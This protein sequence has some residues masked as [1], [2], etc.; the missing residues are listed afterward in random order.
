VTGQDVIPLFR[1]SVSDLEKRY[2]CEALD[3]GWWGQGPRTEEFEGRFAEYA[4]AKHAVAVSSCTAALHLALEALGVRGGQVICPALTFVSTGL[5]ALHAGAQVIFADVDDETLCLDWDDVRAKAGDQTRAVVPVH[6]GGTVTSP[7]FPWLDPVIEDCAH[8]AGSTRAG[9]QNG[10]A[11]CWSFQAV[12][13]LACGDGGMITTDDADIAGTARKLRWCGIERSTWERESRAG[14]NWDYDVP[15]AGWKYQM[16]DIAAAVGLAQLERIEDL[17]KA[18]RGLVLRYMAEL[19]GRVWLRTPR[20]REGSAWH[21]F[22][23]RVPAEM[24]D[25]LISHLLARGISAGVHYKPLNRYPV[26]GERQPLPVT[27]AAWRE[28]VTLPLFPDMTEAQQDRVIA[29][30]RGFRPASLAALWLAAGLARSYGPHPGPG[31][32][33][34]LSIGAFMTRKVVRRLTAPVYGPHGE[35]L[36]E[37]GEIVPLDAELGPDFRTVLDET[38]DDPVQPADPGPAVQPPEPPPLDPPAESG[39]DHA[40][41]T[42]PDPP[43]KGRRHATVNPDPAA[44]KSGAGP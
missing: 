36:H 3:S 27:D 9:R 18:R 10:T 37:P 1:P 13:N 34:S 39:P 38:D 4:G 6:Y 22:Y 28:L 25:A 11:A 43:P 12:K 16:T 32:Y 40:E 24:R 21:L 29:A 2:V 33:P 35:L 31:G 19:P 23:I 20:W 17:N 5:A 7:P 44:G 26:F 15:R 8:A 41:V 14:Y 30:V 42:E